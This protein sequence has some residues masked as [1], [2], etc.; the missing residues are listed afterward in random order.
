MLVWLTAGSAV[1]DDPATKDEPQDEVEI[2]END[3]APTPEAQPTRVAL[4]DPAAVAPTA[5]D[6]RAKQRRTRLIAAAAA[7]VVVIASETI[8]KGVLAPDSCRWCR[9]SELDAGVRDAMIWREPKHADLLSNVGAYGAAPLAAIGLFFAESAG[10]EEGR[11]TRLT[12]DL[13]PVL[14]T[15]AYSQLI[16]QAV[17]FAAGRQRPYARYDTGSYEPGHDDNVSFFSGHSAVTF[18]IAVSMGAVASR[19]GY[20]LAPVIW[21]SGLSVAGA[22]AYLRIAADKHYATDV[23]TGAAFGVAAGLAIPRLTGSLPR[24]VAVAPAPGGMVV[25]GSF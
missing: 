25:A 23:A 15:V 4:I 7:G 8:A 24:S 1:A 18:S 16:N 3:L 11:W 17:K 6:R 5:N 20:R 22:T 13:L 14:E 2:D 21:A 9:V 12:D 19:R 10:A